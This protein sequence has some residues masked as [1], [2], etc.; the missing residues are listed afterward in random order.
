MNQ[1]ADRK[2]HILS[3]YPRIK[4][5][6]LLKLSKMLTFEIG[7]S[8]VGAVSALAVSQ[9]QH[10]SPSLPIRAQ[11]GRCFVEISANRGVVPDELS[12][13]LTFERNF[14]FS[15]CR[16]ISALDISQGHHGGPSAPIRASKGCGFVEISANQGVAP[17]EPSRKLTVEIGFS[18]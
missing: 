8:R 17:A 6:L 5:S 7:D 14:S 12:R 15:H 2:G 1:A 18:D 10:S 3:R 9:G 11:K 13:M 16:A 4:G